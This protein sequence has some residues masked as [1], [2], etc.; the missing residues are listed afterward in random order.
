MHIHHFRYEV[1]QSNHHSQAHYPQATCLFTS[2]RLALPSTLSVSTWKLISN[3]HLSQLSFPN[4]QPIN[5]SITMP[6]LS[7]TN[8][9]SHNLDDLAP[10][11]DPRS[12]P[13]PSCLRLHKD[14]YNVGWPA[15]YSQC[16]VG[17]G[18][19]VLAAPHAWSVQHT[20]TRIHICGRAAYRC[21]VI[22]RVLESN[23]IYHLVINLQRTVCLSS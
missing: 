18:A 16:P 7:P 9:H 19:T 17:A 3:Q 10:P 8:H 15:P 2:A 13:P 23:C 6:L 5:Q 4:H 14:I 22:V 11:S 1:I 20:V 12:S 21:T